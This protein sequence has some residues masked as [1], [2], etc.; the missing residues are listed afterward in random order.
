MERQTYPSPPPHYSEKRAPSKNGVVEST[1]YG[2]GSWLVR[3]RSFTIES[4]PVSN[5]AETLSDHISVTSSQR[6]EEKR[7]LRHVISK[8]GKLGAEGDSGRTSCSTDST[9]RPYDGE[10]FGT[11]IS[12]EAGCR[13]NPRTQR[14]HEMKGLEEAAS[15]KRWTGAGRSADAWGKLAKVSLR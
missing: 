11:T 2:K 15:M 3:R 9:V 8:F 5:D 14:R 6:S 4:S 13:A 7:R 10:Q 12:I 1:N